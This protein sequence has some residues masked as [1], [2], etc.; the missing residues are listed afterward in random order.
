MRRNGQL[1]HAL[2]EVWRNNHREPASLAV[3]LQEFLSAS[4]MDV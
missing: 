1:P 3:V 4:E 2:W